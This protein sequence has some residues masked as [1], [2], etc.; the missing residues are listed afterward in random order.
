MAS[1]APSVS[2]PIV[3]V[4]L[5]LEAEALSG[6]QA[7][8]Y[9]RLRLAQERYDQVYTEAQGG[10]SLRSPST[11][12]TS[13]TG[14][15]G[16]MQDEIDQMRKQLGLKPIYAYD[17]EAPPA[18]PAPSPLP[19]RSMTSYGFSMGWGAPALGRT[20]TA[21]SLAPPP[22]VR[23]D[24]FAAAGGAS[25]S[26][27][28]GAAISAVEDDA[29]VDTLMDQLRALRASLQVRQDKVYEESVGSHSD[30]SVQDM[31]WEDLDNKIHAIEG[32]LGAF[33][34]VYRQR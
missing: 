29:S 23:V 4:Q 27:G 8:L 25:P 5:D 21:A 26:G 7:E 9:E 31:E 24:A 17:V 10:C 2:L 11:G 12:M 34:K 14:F 13:T 20:M 15:L 1:L 33:R 30:M 22:L 6:P 19:A 28:I 18:A 32:V 3:G 16:A